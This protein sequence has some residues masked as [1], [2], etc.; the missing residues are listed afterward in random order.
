MIAEF[1]AW[2]IRRLLCGHTVNGE[3][4]G[5]SE[6]LQP[7]GSYLESLDPADRF[8][9]WEGYLCSRCDRADVI[10]ALANANPL[11]PPPQVQP[12]TF[13]TAA[14]V[15]KIM[16]TMHWLWELWIP[17]S[18]IV[19][20]A[21]LEG[22]GKTRFGLDLCRRV[23]NALPWPDG[24]VMTLPPKTPSLWLCA[25]GHHDE[26][27]DMLP[28]FGLPDEAVIFPAPSD[29]PYSNT[30]LDAP[31]TLSQ[32]D[33]AI[34]AHRPG[35]V[36]VDSLT[37]A[38]SRDL[39][40]QRSIAILKTP[41]VELVQRHQVNI[42]LL[43]HV[44]KEGQALGRRIKGITRTLIH[45]ECPD[46]EQSDRL[47]LWV[48]KSYGKKPPALGVTMRDGGNDYDSNPPTRPDPNRGGRPATK[49]E[50]AA[51]F[52][53]EKLAAQNDR[54]GND[55][56]SEFAATGGTGSTFWRAVR[57]MGA[58]G[59]LTLD[60]GK[61]TGKQTMLHLNSVETPNP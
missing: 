23:W 34:V 18:R 31:E 16:A 44:S 50:Q 20:I 53:C 38:T 52:I 15:R 25:D 9:P 3:L 60:G 56:A 17:A 24:Q 40:E 4:A 14:D 6:G 35:F 19:G 27:A 2:T 59:E 54:I 55:L 61:G 48:E 11:G 45:L 5:L 43:L 26:I 37:Y 29:D 33:D 12:V 22:T 47:R 7:I 13:A 57:E 28:S 36:F 49:R 42:I 32:V 10:V 1:D 30:S 39:C 51:R 41:L 46:A 58:N 21:G 8:G